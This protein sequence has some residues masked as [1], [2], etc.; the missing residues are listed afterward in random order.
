MK[1]AILFI[2]IALPCAIAALF[3]RLAFPSAMI[4]SFALVAVLFFASLPWTAGALYDR[5]R[6]RN[7]RPTGGIVVKPFEQQPPDQEDPNEL[8]RAHPRD[9][10]R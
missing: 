6:T 8:A 3:I 9:I 10:E 5:W 7:Q 2:A 4:V 1:W